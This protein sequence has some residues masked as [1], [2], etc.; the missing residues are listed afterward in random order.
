M[1]IPFT[2]F[3]F[4]ASCQFTPLR[5]LR[6]LIFRLTT[7]GW[8]RTFFFF[9]PAKATMIHPTEEQKPDMKMNN[10]RYNM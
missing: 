8:L 1:P 4:N 7:F 10:N 5:D 9:L 2:P 3:C 6:S